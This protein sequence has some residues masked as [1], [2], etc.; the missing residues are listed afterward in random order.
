MILTQTQYIPPLKAR[1]QSRRKINRNVQESDFVAN[2]E[3]T[4]VDGSQECDILSEPVCRELSDDTKVNLVLIARTST[5][6]CVMTNFGS[7][8][9]RRGPFKRSQRA[10]TVITNDIISPFPLLHSQPLMILLLPSA[11]PP[12]QFNLPR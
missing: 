10:N 8:P 12:S 7:G 3:A 11:F 2:A 9:F 5:C 1:R 4:S 6:L